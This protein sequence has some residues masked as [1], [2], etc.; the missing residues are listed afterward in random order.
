MGWT[1]WVIPWMGMTTIC[2]TL[3]MTVRV[4]TYR[5]PPYRW[6]PE[7]RTTVT[8]LSVDCMM[9]GATPS[10]AI[11]PITRRRGRRFRGRMRKPERREQR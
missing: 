3:W 1:P 7:L 8:R 4:P 6:S 2:M 5:S 9:N 11:R 10:P